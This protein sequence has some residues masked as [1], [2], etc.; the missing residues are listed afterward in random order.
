M[1]RMSCINPNFYPNLDDNIA[2]QLHI[3]IK[4]LEEQEIYPVKYTDEGIIFNNGQLTS[5][6]DILGSTDIIIDTPEPPY[7]SY[8]GF[9]SN[10]EYNIH[11]NRKTKLEGFMREL[12]VTDIDVFEDLPLSVLIDKL[13][14]QDNID[15]GRQLGVNNVVLSKDMTLGQYL[16]ERLRYQ[17]L[18]DIELTDAKVTDFNTYVLLNN[19]V[20]NDN[21]KLFPNM[22]EK[23]K[24]NYLQK[25]LEPLHKYGLKLLLTNLKNKTGI[26]YKF[27]KTKEFKARIAF[28][29]VELSD[30][31]SANDVIHEYLHPFVLALQAENPDLYNT[32]INIP[33]IKEQTKYFEN[34][35]EYSTYAQEEALV[36]YMA[37]NAQISYV[38]QFYNWLKSF[39]KDLLGIKTS[40]NLSK[41]SVDTTIQDL[42]SILIDANMIDINSNYYRYHTRYNIE[43]ATTITQASLKDKFTNLDE[44]KLIYEYEKD[45][46]LLK[47]EQEPLDVIDVKSYYVKK[48]IYLDSITDT[49][50]YT[51]ASDAIG[52]KTDAV[53]SEEQLR[54]GKA[55]SQVGTLFHNIMEEVLLESRELGNIF[56]DNEKWQ[57]FKDKVNLPTIEVNGV[58]FLNINKIVEEKDSFGTIKTEFKK[59]TKK[60][61]NEIDGLLELIDGI[62]IENSENTIKKIQNKLLSKFLESLTGLDTHASDSLQKLTKI[63]NGKKVLK[64][65][66]ELKDINTGK[67]KVLIQQIES[68]R[69]IYALTF[70]NAESITE[71]KA[72]IVNAYIKYLNKVVVTTTKVNREGEQR[73]FKYSSN[74]FAS[75]KK[76]TDKITKSTE[77]LLN[78]IKEFIRVKEGLPYTNEANYVTYTNAILDVARELYLNIYKHYG[79]DAIILPEI[80]IS[81]ENYN[82]QKV[83]GTIDAL[84]I[85]KNGELGILDYKTIGVNL[86]KELLNPNIT[87]RKQIENVIKQYGDKQY[88][89]QEILAEILTGSGVELISISNALMLVT[90]KREYIFEKEGILDFIKNEVIKTKFA[91]GHIIKEISKMDIGLSK[92]RIIFWIKNLP[93]KLQN[94]PIDSIPDN[95]AHKVFGAINRYMLSKRNEIYKELKNLPENANKSF[96]EL[97]NMTD[98]KFEYKPTKV[99]IKVPKKDMIKLFPIYYDKHVNTYP[100]KLVVYKSLLIYY[101]EYIERY[102]V[103]QQTMLNLEENGYIKEIIDRSLFNLKTKLDLLKK[104]ENV[105]DDKVVE[106]WIKTAFNTENHSVILSLIHNIGN[107]EVNT[108]A[109]LNKQQVFNK[110]TF[111]FSKYMESILEKYVN[112]KSLKEN[113]QDELSKQKKTILQEINNRKQNNSKYK[114]NGETLQVIYEDEEINKL[115]NKLS[116]INTELN[117]LTISIN[118]YN[119]TI[120]DIRKAIEKLHVMYVQGIKDFNAGQIYA[121]VQDIFKITEQFV[122]DLEKPIDTENYDKDINARV[123]KFEFIEKAI[124]VYGSFAQMLATTADTVVIGDK[125]VKVSEQIREYGIDILESLKDTNPELYKNINVLTLQFNK[126]LRDRANIAYKKFIADVITRNSTKDDTEYR[127]KVLWFKTN[128]DILSTMIEEDKLDIE[129]FKKYLFKLGYKETEE[130][131]INLVNLFVNNKQQ[132]GKELNLKYEEILKGYTEKRNEW[133]AEEYDRLHKELSSN[134]LI[135]I[136]NV[137][138]YINESFLG[139]SQS[140]YRIV[141]LLAILNTKIEDNYVTLFSNMV[142][143]LEHNTALILPM[144]STYQNKYLNRL[145]F[146]K[147]YNFNI[148]IAETED[149]EL[150]KEYLIKN[151][152]FVFDREDLEAFAK[153]GVSIQL[154]VTD[155]LVN[156]YKIVKTNTLI[157]RFKWGIRNKFKNVISTIK[158]FNYKES[159]QGQYVFFPITLSKEERQR[160]I[161]NHN[162]NKRIV[163][164]KYIK[165]YKETYY[166]F[167]YRKYFLNDYL[168]EGENLDR[169]Y[170]DEEYK[171]RMK[172]TLSTKTQEEYRQQIR[173]EM[174]K[175]YGSEKYVEVLLQ[176]IE[177]KYYRYKR[178][179][180]IES[181]LLMK[182]KFR[183]EAEITQNFEKYKLQY[184]KDETDNFVYTGN[185][186]KQTFFERIVKEA[187]EDY[188]TYVNSLYTQYSPFSHSEQMLSED[189]DF[190]VVYKTGEYYK[191]SNLSGSNIVFLPKNTEENRDKRFDEVL[192]SEQLTDYYFYLRHVIKQLHNLI[193]FDS[194]TNHEP[195]ELPAID[196]SIFEKLLSVH[197]LTD[198]SEFTK[199]SM[200]DLIKEN[201]TS[202]I[203]NNYDEPH[204]NI[205]TLSYSDTND[206]SL[207]RRKTRNLSTQLDKTIQLFMFESLLF[208]TRYEM[209]P[210]NHLILKLSKYSSNDQLRESVDF[211]YIQNMIGSKVRNITD[212]NPNIVLTEE[213]KNEVELLTKKIKDLMISK[214]I[215]SKEKSTITE[216]E[217]YWTVKELL[218]KY[219]DLIAQIKQIDRQ[220]NSYYDNIKLIYRKAAIDVHTIERNLIAPVKLVGLSYN[221]V[222]QVNNLLI[223]FI[224]TKNRAMSSTEERT[225]YLDAFNLMDKIITPEKLMTLAGITSNQVIDMLIPIPI[226][227]KLAG[228]VG[229]MITMAFIGSNIDK[230]QNNITSTSELL[231]SDRVLSK[232][233]LTP[234]LVKVINM[235]TNYNFTNDITEE[236]KTGQARPRLTVDAQGQVIDTKNQFMNLLRPYSFIKRAELFVAMFSMLIQAKLMKVKIDGVEY[237]FFDIHD[238]QGNIKDEFKPY[239]TDTMVNLF[240]RKTIQRMTD[241]SGNYR[242]KTQIEKYPAATASTLYMKWIWQPVQHMFHR[243]TNASDNVF[244]GQDSAT[245]GTV[246]SFVNQVQK[247]YL[248]IINNAVL[249]SKQLSDIEFLKPELIDVTIDEITEEALS[250]KKFD[251]FLNKFGKN[252]GKN[253]N[254]RIVL[255]EK[256]FIVHNSQIINNFIRERR[257]ALDNF[258]NADKELLI[259]ALEFILNKSIYKNI[260]LLTESTKQDRQDLTIKLSKLILSLL[261]PVNSVPHTFSY[262]GK[263]LNRSTTEILDKYFDKNT[264][265]FDEYEK[266]HYESLQRFTSS[267]HTWIS[268][269]Y[270]SI[271]S[272]ILFSLIVGLFDLDREDEAYQ[273]MQSFDNRFNRLY[274]DVIFFNTG[275]P[276]TMFINNPYKVFN[277]TFGTWKFYYNKVLPL[278]TDIEALPF[279]TLSEVATTDESITENILESLY[280]NAGLK[281]PYTDNPRGDFTNYRVINDAID[282]IPLANKLQQW[283]KSEQYEQTSN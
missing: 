60:E 92:K 204:S 259:N 202:I 254:S 173:E 207:L 226:V 171:N 270:Y 108:N 222:G 75:N 145:G 273:I 73:T 283:E 66:K 50:K 109:M 9:S 131:F 37:K 38:K 150:N 24:Y 113:E 225:A 104:I 170:E 186:N 74:P 215:L 237:T 212:K 141:Q 57:A 86:F 219:Y 153:K 260:R 211:N 107:V 265:N 97:N 228:F 52:K 112:N 268:W 117:K 281:H 88:L 165:E 133:N 257:Q 241:A 157:D 263:Q 148:F 16:D 192:K 69:D 144:L 124:N 71:R 125:E 129:N 110:Q 94:N 85:G 48:D 184:T 45:G 246:N 242:E 209:Y 218:L 32:L 236:G 244:T 224:Q 135:T 250:D 239:I 120:N 115:N 208:K 100:S 18:P 197:K 22:Y 25:L 162:T 155:E 206:L 214:D 3:K 187:E 76:L 101:I 152:E 15:I 156:K 99:V 59:F 30:T 189:E 169:Y 62:T 47:S 182:A 205:T 1:N 68:L 51:R 191:I 159:P 272:K 64:F 90:M 251:K 79:E 158:D 269:T 114:I 201:I 230:K 240:K 266:A 121:E 275:N 278:I 247:S 87:Q 23:E 142:N 55:S 81:S 229:Q 280:K 95:D 27:V 248:K 179:N 163:L 36:R 256:G 217:G 255:Y 42:L 166:L 116:A 200:I 198:L 63:V 103:E 262:K 56:I 12:G 233:A 245:S 140:S 172:V 123:A 213:A 210:L 118:S 221:L 175:E 143:E 132:I 82:G 216:T 54:V 93:K 128:I 138:K 29:V 136:D 111:A 276:V 21:W 41:L 151:Y 126:D 267:I 134:K 174:L 127:E 89:Y 28:G 274:Q 102:R 190:D 258:K 252:I 122:E 188:Y 235:N 77:P 279:Y 194:K 176:D 196:E 10:S 227:G 130:E 96:I 231:F 78:L 65:S 20:P 178:V 67:N 232:V 70:S 193:P 137:F 46:I 14:V 243:T 149:K 26:D 160:K 146:D 7:F 31:I 139:A 185:D 39:I 44:F 33:E 8:E 261:N 35:Q 119:S 238:N 83:A 84:I 264:H 105:N 6:A 147:N 49:D 277:S 5:I 180:G 98:E 282:I 13:E 181:G 164:D 106:F 4:Q 2:N 91:E 34:T 203:P 253:F 19:D 40:T 58:L 271:L 199:K 167:D 72:N 53:Y 249:M 154:F 43:N 234:E 177:E 223:G 161:N 17:D 61:I 183:K 80:I 11:M 220:I 168:K 195:L